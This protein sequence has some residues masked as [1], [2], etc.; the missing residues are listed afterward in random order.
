MRL[1]DTLSDLSHSVR[2]IAKSCAV[3]TGVGAL[4]AGL[5]SLAPGADPGGDAE[6]DPVDALYTRFLLHQEHHLRHATDLQELVEP[7]PPELAPVFLGPEDLWLPGLTAAAETPS[8]SQGVR[9]ALGLWKR[10]H[11]DPEAALDLFHHENA[12]FP[13]AR[14]RQVELETALQSENFARLDA[15]EQDP[16]YRKEMKGYFR[17][18]QGMQ[19]GDWG[20]VLRHFLPAAYSHTQRTPLLLSL[21]SGAIWAL[22]ILSLFPNR[23]TRSQWGLALL[24]LALGWVSTWPT[25]LSG[26]WMHRTFT[27]DEGTEFLSTLFYMV[28]SVGLR[29]EVIKLLL[30]TPFLLITRKPGRDLDALLYGALVGL[31]FAIEENIQYF[32]QGSGGVAVSRFV[33]ANMLHFLLTGSTALAL[34]RAVRDPGRWSLDGFQILLM[35]IGLHGL[36]NTLL[37]HPVPGLGDMSYFSGSALAGCAYLFFREVQSLQPVRAPT[38]TRTAAFC[39]GYCLLFS[40]ELGWASSQVGFNDALYLTGQAALA[41]VLTGY[42]FLHFIREA[43]NP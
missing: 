7:L 39:W 26:M 31:G 35:A 19:T 17:M 37:S 42:I 18:T 41:G 6:V 33:S 23:P 24:A 16:V 22:P 27:L 11:Q 4:I 34:T 25:V 40:L 5:I 36:Y 29:E 2:G 10:R 3:L 12:D 13:H 20:M 1:R 8:P 14:V 43:L 9:F 30:Y 15:L 32:S 21:I 38:I 28:V